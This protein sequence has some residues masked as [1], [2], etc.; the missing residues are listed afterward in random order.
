MRCWHCSE[1]LIWR[2][3]HDSDD[4]GY[5]M[6]TSLHCP[7]C[8]SEVMVSLPDNQNKDYMHVLTVEAGEVVR[9]E[10]DSGLAELKKVLNDHGI[11]ASLSV[12]IRRK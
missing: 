8:E 11:R 3:D 10:G 6:D 4:D 9:R 1:K 7:G 2:G 12:R 5:V